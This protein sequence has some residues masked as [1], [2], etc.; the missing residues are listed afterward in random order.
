MLVKTN[1]IRHVYVDGSYF[2]NNRVTCFLQQ[3]WV[4]YV[5]ISCSWQDILKGGGA[6][7]F[8]HVWTWLLSIS[9]NFGPA[10]LKNN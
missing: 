7:E 9:E 6:L 4:L 5:D 2:V 10:V 3:P 8:N 1:K